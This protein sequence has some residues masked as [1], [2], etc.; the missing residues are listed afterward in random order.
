[1]T[2]ERA[3]NRA[4]IPI[5]YTQG[6]NRRPRLS[7]AS[8]LPLGFLS[9]YELADIWLKEEM[10]PASAQAQMMSRMAPGIEI[11][12]VREVPLHEDSLQSRILAAHYRVTLLDAVDTAELAQKIDD[13]LAAESCLRRRLRGKKRKEY[14]LRPL[15]LAL[16]IIDPDAEGRTRLRMRLR[17]EPGYTGRPDEVLDSLGLDPLAAR[18]CRTR[19]ALPEDEIAPEPIAG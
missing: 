16:S 19:L 8:P 10:D 1:L 11:Y 3:L 15:I 2:L 14:D 18:I 5:A 13:L 17:Q 4:N 7:I 6:Y 9:E 12:R